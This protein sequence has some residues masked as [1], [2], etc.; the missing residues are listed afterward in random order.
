MSNGRPW[1]G[2]ELRRLGRLVAAGLTD[3]QIG[4][5]LDRDRQNVQRKRTELRLKPGQSPLMTV[6]VRRLRARR[7]MKGNARA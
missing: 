4:E 3:A 1:S 7:R 2:K 6:M 5:A